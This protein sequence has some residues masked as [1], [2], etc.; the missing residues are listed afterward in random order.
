MVTASFWPVVAEGLP[1]LSWNRRTGRLF[2]KQKVHCPYQA[3]TMN[4]FDT[5]NKIMVY[6][7]IVFN[8]VIL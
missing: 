6:T 3:K 7:F 8:H 4:T 2:L 5:I 1:G